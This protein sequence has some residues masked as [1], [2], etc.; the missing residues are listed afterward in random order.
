MSQAIPN[1]P[2]DFTLDDIEGNAVALDQYRGRV[3]LIVNVASQCGLTPQYAALQKLYTELQERG[4]V[5]LGIPA[6]EFGRQEPGTNAEIQTFCSTRYGVT[7]PMFAKIV[8][9]GEGQHPLY[10]FL[11]DK[12]TNPQYGGEIEWNFAK[13][14]VNRKGEIAGRIPA[15]VDPT[16]PEVL[17]QLETLLAE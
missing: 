14:L 9:E 10:R 6:N 15:N 3:A 13:F 1:S 17:A 4:L 2:L 11:T 16:T 5:V 8:V 7:F 12:E